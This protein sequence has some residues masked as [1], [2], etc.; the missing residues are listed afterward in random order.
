[1]LCCCRQT[2]SISSYRHRESGGAVYA[3]KDPSHVIHRNFRGLVLVT[4][5]A[6]FGLV[7]L[8]G[9]VRTTDSGLGCPDWPLCYGGLLPLEQ[10]H[11]TYI[12]FSHRVVAGVVGLLVAGVMIAAWRQYRRQRWVFV[13]ALVGF[14][15]LVVQALIGGVTVLNEL[16]RW[17]VIVHLAMAQ[18]MIAV[19]LVVYV[20]SGHAGNGASLA[21][22]N[23]A[24][25]R[26]PAMAV[27]SALATF[28]LMMVGSYVAN[29]A[30]ATYVCGDSWPLCRGELLQQDGLSLIHMGHRAAALVV[31][32]VVAATVAMAWQQRRWRPQL[33]TIASVAGLLFLVQVFVGGANMW[34]GFPVAVKVVH[35]SLA[36]ATWMG[37]A[38]LAILALSRQGWSLGWWE[39]AIKP[40]QLPTTAPL[41]PRR[42]ILSVV[43]DHLTLTKPPI[44]LLLLVTALGGM[45][46]ASQGLPPVATAL[47]LLLGGTLGAGGANSMNH[48]LE[49][50][51]DS[52][53]K[54]T[55][56]RPVPGNRIDARVALAQGV[57]LNVVAFLILT[58]QVNVLSALLTLSAT[59]FYVLVYTCWMKRTTPQNI[60][61]GGAAG[62]VPPLAGWA[63]ITGGLDLPAVYLFAI[64]FFWT[65]PHFWALSL[66]MKDDY[67][68]AGIPMLPVVRG[69]PETAR[70]IMLYSL[71]LVALTVMFFIIPEVGWIYFFLS[72][73]LGALFLL[74]AWRLLY[75]GGSRGAKALY[76]YS[77]AYL[78]L[79]FG[80][81][82]VDS[83]VAL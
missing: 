11:S 76:L 53:M 41:A 2:V 65:P 31:G 22:A 72:I 3:S 61:I 46:L 68:R 8:G 18:G 43:A 57:I 51:I 32:V 10:D 38:L 27:S 52:L 15:L 63:A 30:G 59:V 21:S 6:L 25:S 71:L 73:G 82:M 66:L 48:A 4:L 77:L 1:M 14:A 80:G 69:V 44:I 62:A 67:E 56:S 9:V 55:R 28:A 36:T 37:L 70:S 5:I 79:L 17:S 34:F 7:T 81:I 33:W 12:E 42:G 26:F 40:S 16:P 29:T 83:T 20:A 19:L 47:W 74:M 50:D 23:R 13:P 58:T 39:K 78:A 49:R 24:P 64:I 45:F 75:S 60:V 35:L 54:R